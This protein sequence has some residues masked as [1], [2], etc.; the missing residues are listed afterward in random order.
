[1]HAVELSLR[2]WARE[3]PGTMAPCCLLCS[4]NAEDSGTLGSP[5]SQVAVHR[6]PSLFLF[7]FLFLDLRHSWP[8]IKLDSQRSG[9][10]VRLKQ[11]LE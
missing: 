1:M 3:F 4:S 6:T 10:N 7:L 8:L 11:M 2:I 5:V 9:G